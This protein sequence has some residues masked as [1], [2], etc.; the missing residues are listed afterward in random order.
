[1]KTFFVL[2]LALVI[3]GHRSTAQAQDAGGPPQT[4]KT[5]LD[6]N[7]AINGISA[8]ETPLTMGITTSLESQVLNE[9]RV[10]NIYLPPSYQEASEQT[11]PVIYLLDGAVHEDYPHQSGLVQF[12]TMY[13]LMPESIVIGI[14]NTDRKR[15]LTS[16]TTD[17]EEV[18]AFPT[19][20]GSAKFLKFL[21]TE[22]QPFVT[23]RFRTSTM[24][25]LIGQSLGGLFATEVLVKKPELFDNYIIVSPSLYWS[26][27]QL[28]NELVPF[29][30]RNTELK[31]NIFLSIGT[32][33]PVMHECMD[34][35]VAALEKH[36]PEG[37]KWQYTALPN[38]THATVMHR[39]TYRAYEFLYGDD[40]EGM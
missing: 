25:T 23:N 21:E 19:A 3:L 4:A 32:E 22:L 5:M 28:L 6:A 2:V 20:G 8:S 15:D 12:M 36:S 27:E 1:M 18:Q 37:I 14:A 17:Q 24:R 30:K 31:K 11:Y 7:Q 39:A 16:A 26:H 33:H 10:L 29:L 40:Y 38:E 9:T 13:Q 35:F 34:R